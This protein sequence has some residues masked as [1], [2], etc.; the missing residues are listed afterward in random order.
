MG[1]HRSP[2]NVSRPQTRRQLD[3]R[4]ARLIRRVCDGDT[5]AFEELVRPYERLV[6]VTAITVLRN[7]GDAEEVAQEAILKAFS[8]LSTF[9]AESKFSAWLVQIIYNEAQNGRR[10]PRERISSLSA[11]VNEG[12]NFL[13]PL[14]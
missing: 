8:N 13:E 7:E 3:S 5:Q 1:E 4:E 6:F 11:L 12:G 10:D 9:R 2:S 14:L